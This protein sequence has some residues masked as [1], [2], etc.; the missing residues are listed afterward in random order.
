MHPLPLADGAKK[1]FA[2]PLA[3]Q[4]GEFSSAKISPAPQKSSIPV[5]IDATCCALATEIVKTLCLCYF[6]Q[7]TGGGAMIWTVGA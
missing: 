4:S 5:A 1:R 6:L 3:K 2:S 7:M